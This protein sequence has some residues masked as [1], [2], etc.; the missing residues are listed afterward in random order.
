MKSAILISALFI[1]Y[2]HSVGQV[3][4]GNF[5]VLGI[6]SIEH[7]YV[8]NLIDSAGVKN[9]LLSE[10][11][12]DT[13][14]SCNSE[15]KQLEVNHWYYLKV[16]RQYYVLANK[17]KNMYINLNEMNYYVDD[18]FIVGRSKIPYRSDYVI[19]NCYCLKPMLFNEN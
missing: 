4:D 3:I 1:V 19:R 5:K 11:T 8:I 10:K 17:E 13:I 16:E 18:R 15:M 9:I 2:S 6:D 14:F 7:Y 12:P